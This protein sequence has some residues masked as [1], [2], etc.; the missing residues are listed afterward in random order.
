VKRK[1]PKKPC[2]YT[3]DPPIA[4]KDLEAMPRPALKGPIKVEAAVTKKNLG[5][6]EKAWRALLRLRGRN[7][8]GDVTAKVRVRGGHAVKARPHYLIKGKKKVK[9]LRT[10]DPSDNPSEQTAWESGNR[11][12]PSNTGNCGTQDAKKK[13]PRREAGPRGHKHRVTGSAHL[14]GP[15]TTY[16]KENESV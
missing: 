6:N 11:K 10:D 7:E 15:G 1:T 3:A 9:E 16:R 12:D 2:K 8:P 5:T 4:K 13:N 14:K